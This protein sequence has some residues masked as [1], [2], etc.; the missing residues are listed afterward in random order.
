MTTVERG[1]I[2][3]GPVALE[4]LAGL[5]AKT[6]K[7]R[8]VRGEPPPPEHLN[9]NHPSERRRPCTPPSR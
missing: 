3:I 4:V 9:P 7:W 1:P 5:W 8:T 2:R 6:C